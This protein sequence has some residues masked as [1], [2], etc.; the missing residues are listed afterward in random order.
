MALKK[1]EAMAYTCHP[2]YCRVADRI[3]KDERCETNTMLENKS[4]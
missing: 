3:R 4:T 1:G 2:L